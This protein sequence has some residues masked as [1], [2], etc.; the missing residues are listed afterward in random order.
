MQLD[1]VGKSFGAIKAVSPLT[2]RIAQGERVALLGPS[3]SGKTTLL[4]MIAGT[5]APT[6]GAIALR[7]KP[8]AGMRP[9]RDLAALV[10][11]VHQ[12]FDLVPHLSALNNVLAGRL[13]QWSAAAAMLSLLWPRDKDR[14]I[15]ALER[16][17]VAQRAYVRAGRLS[18][19]EQ[20]RV[21][22]ARLLLQ[23]PAII[24]ADEPIAS[25]DPTRAEE[26][27]A[28][29][30]ATAQETG[31]TLVA[32]I[33][34]VSLARRHF[35]RIAGMRNGA[36]QFDLPAHQVTNDLLDALYALPGLR[37]EAQSA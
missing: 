16:V 25:L 20:Q 11:M 19:G 37:D 22:I 21:A 2:L 13:G 34:A 36:V 28:L 33:H 1:A 8:L 24:L 18:G 26:I 4:A 10:G 30:A 23:D 17:G 3:G 9:G 15:A 31:K 7:G 6:T 5:T 35:T 29:L 12:Q 14:G 32:S 27:I